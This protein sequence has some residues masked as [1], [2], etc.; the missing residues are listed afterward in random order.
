MHL[1]EP[2]RYGY[3]LRTSV[4]TLVTLNTLVGTLFLFKPTGTPVAKAPGP[5][6]IVHYDFIVYL[7]DT[8]YIHA[9]G[10]GHAVFATGTGDGT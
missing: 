6:V 4:H 8:R 10:T 9:I 5:G 3:L 2:L 7:E 1:L